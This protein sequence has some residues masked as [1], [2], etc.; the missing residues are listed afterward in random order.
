MATLNM[1]DD[2]LNDQTDKTTLPHLPST[3]GKLSPSTALNNTLQK[4]ITAVARYHRA[5]PTFKKKSEAFWIFAAGSWTRKQYDEEV[6]Q[7]MEKL[8]KAKYVDEDLLAAR[9]LVLE[10][11]EVLKKAEMLDAKDLEEAW[12]VFEKGNGRC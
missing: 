5:G 4:I 3:T 11:I 9:R 6:R 12:R 1:L 10:G 7:A 2:W 8:P